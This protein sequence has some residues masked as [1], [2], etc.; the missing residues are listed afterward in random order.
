[1]KS[2]YPPKWFGLSLLVAVLLLAAS[3]PGRAQSGPYGNEWIVPGQQYV[4]IKIWRDGIY[5]LDNQY[6]SRT[7]LAIANPARLQL[8]RRGRE[9]AVFVGGS[10]TGFDASTFLEFFGQRNDGRLDAEYYKDP[11]EQPHQ[12]YSLDTDTAAYF[13]TY[14]AQPGRRM[15]EPLPAAGPLHPYRLVSS[16]KLKTNFYREVAGNTHLPW[17]QG[18]EGFMGEDYSGYSPAEPLDSLLRAILASPAPRLEAVIVSPNLGPHLIRA[19]VE[20]PGAPERELGRFPFSG[21]NPGR[22]RATLQKS[23]FTARG[24]VAIRFGIL[25]TPDVPR[26][27]FRVTYYRITAAQ[28]NRWYPDRHR[29]HFHNDSTLAGPATFELDSIPATVVG[30][31][32]HDPWNVQ[33]VAGTAG[34][35]R[36]R[37]YVFPDATGQQTRQLLLADAAYPL[38]PGQP[39]RPVTFRRLDPARSNYIIITHPRLM[40]PAAGVPNAAR[41][42][43]DYRASAAGG[44]HDT[45]LVTAP[46]L[47]DQFHYG[48]RSVLALR[49]FA[50]WLADSSPATAPTRYLLLL[51]QGIGP[52]ETLFPGS[53]G[54]TNTMRHLNDFSQDLV[55]T[56]TRAP[57]DNFLSSDWPRGNYV[58]RLPTGR[59]VAKSAAEVMAYLNKLREYEAPDAELAD[60]HKR[61]LN[62]VGGREENEYAEFGA[63]LA[64]YQRRI[65]RP[66]FSGRVVRT[67]NRRDYPGNLPV[68][69]EAQTEVN[70]GLGLITYFG[71]GSNTTFNL[72]LGDAAKYN[73][74]GKYPFLFFFGGCEAAHLTVSAPTFGANWLLTPERGAV[75]LMGQTGRG[76]AYPLNKAQDLMYQLLLNDPAWYGRPVTVAYAETV[77][78][79]QLDPDFAVFGEEIA[80]EQLL[81]TTWHG[82]PALTL[83]APPRPDFIAADAQLSVRPVAGQ[84][85]PVEAGTRR[86]VLSIGVSNPGRITADSLEIEV[87]RQYGAG[88]PSTV[89]RQ[90]FRQAS[91]RDT[92]YAFVL[93]NEGNVFGQNVFQVKLDYRNKV[94]ELSEANNSAQTTYSFLSGGVS[95]LSPPE[96]AIVPTAAPLLVAQTNDPAGSS[97][98]YAFELDTVPTF[99]SPLL[100][101]HTATGALT[102]DW[103]PTLPAVAGRDSIVWYW[104]ARFA[105]PGA[106]PSEDSRFVLSSFRHISGSPAGWSQSHYGQFQ[107]DE[108]RGVDVATPSGRWHFAEEKRGLTLATTGGGPANSAPTFNVAGRLGITA[109][110][111]APP[112]VSNCAAQAPGLLVAVYDQ[113]TLQPLAVAGGPYLA[114][115]QAS[116]PYYVFGANPS[117]PTDTLNNL[118][119]SAERQ[120]ELVHLLTN[121]PDGAYVALVSMNRLRYA[122]LPPAVRTSLGTLLG[123][124][125]IAENQLRNGDP[126]ALLAQK[127]AG[128]GRLIRESG[129]DLAPAAPARATQL[130]SLSDTLR[131]G[132]TRGTLLSTRIGPAR[133]WGTLYHRIETETPTGT[134]TLRLLGVDAQGNTAVLYPDI[135]SR[136]LNVDTVSSSRF[137]YLQLELNL[138]D[139]ENRT[140]PQLQQ[141]LLTYTGVPEGVV[142]RDLAPAG[143][144]EAA[145]LTRQATQDGSLSLPVVFKNVSGLAFGAPLNARVSLR[146]ASGNEVRTA[147]VTAATGALAAGASV[148]FSARIDVRGLFGT[149]TAQVEVNPLL[150]NPNL[151]PELYHFN[152]LL[153]LPP[154]TL[155]DRNVPPVLDVAF[156][157]RRILSGELVSPTPLI[158]IQLRDED[159]LRHIRD[160]R[161]F[162]VSL[163]RPGQAAPTPIDLNSADILFRAD[164]TSRPGTTATLEFQ[165]GRQAKLE[166]G[167]YTLRVQGRDPGNLSAGTQDYQ[168]RFEVVS[169]SAITNVYPYP[170]PVTSKARFVFTLTGQELPRNMKIQIMTLT[171]K[172]VREI[173]M[174]ELGPLHIGNNLTDYAWDGTDQYGDRLANGTYLYRVSL[175]DAAGTFSRRETGGDKAFKNDWG[176]LVLLR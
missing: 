39:A 27:L 72:N 130:L 88:R 129:P 18:A 32:V 4:K 78:R 163:Q 121:V 145:T 82:D 114:C 157:G 123:S 118:N 92:T 12:L 46:Q 54:G 166:D 36:R 65:E 162:T 26:D 173:F 43:A 11:A 25:T 99:N 85:G 100:Q 7:G 1:M 141:W 6:L 60:W 84:A 59:V 116:Q 21:L 96:F 91:R 171:G 124:R 137:P 128:G 19:I 119:N 31:D 139:A 140:P 132:G 165:P 22:F 2:F 93:E 8:W 10:A 67:F 151:Q 14:G 105:T 3:Q 56:T 115:G 49:Y 50:L 147:L 51:G 103:Q 20:P 64:G 98:P 117:S 58:A 97:R 41:A 108:R 75:A 89:H 55:P 101:R 152:N 146:D 150:Q 167:I 42:Y 138:L 62:L 73:N 154:I 175:D 5:R 16:L 104:R 53:R 127:R 80:A 66:P 122:A 69:V 77:R 110:P 63:Y 126:F 34:E 81:T 48:E 13:L 161:Y 153:T 164:S 107:R 155:T 70:P 90:T 106:D 15:A 136:A 57:S 76:Y 149:L 120:A 37:R 35:G 176:K 144:Y 68:E 158:S 47:Y 135:K 40:L 168:V 24:D 45:L 28:A 172:V 33:R 52:N 102:A 109:D 133:Q 74:R 30:Y 170:N 61:A 23:E 134:Y 159:Q 29:L 125:L 17:L 44:R 94:A 38:A 95:L 156:D 131:T 87:T 148:T 79:L 174:P 143:A 9:V 86:F 112:F 83:F 111:T 160:A 71:H 169:K 142:R 113:R